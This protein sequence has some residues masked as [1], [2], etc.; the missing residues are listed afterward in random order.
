MS[1][2][3]KDISNNKFYVDKKDFWES[4]KEYKKLCETNPNAK[5]PDRAAVHLMNICGGMVK[6]HN[7]RGYSF[8]DEMYED[9]LET[10]IKY[11]KKFDP[12]KG[13][14]PYGY[15]FT[16]AYR[17][18]L[19]RIE[20]EEKQQAIKAKYIQNMIIEDNDNLFTD[21]DTGE[22]TNYVGNFFSFDLQAYEEKQKKK[23]N[24]KT[25]K[26]QLKTKK[27][28]SEVDTT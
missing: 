23:R 25:K 16:T 21:K 1:T 26:M 27:D 22:Y 9:A 24:K 8:V 4:T 2:K 17:V 5:I 11:F 10:C 28:I 15:F 7:F 6:R 19:T 20:L 12:D 18:C 3:K 14:N 13:K